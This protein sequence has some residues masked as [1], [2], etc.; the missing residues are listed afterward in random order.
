[1][2]RLMGFLYCLSKGRRR[3]SVTISLGNWVASVK[4]VL[5]QF[6]CSLPRLGKAKCPGRAQTNIAPLAIAL[7]AQN[8]RPRPARLYKQI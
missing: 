8:P 7:D 1:M 3:R 6:G 4:R 2:Q 5:A